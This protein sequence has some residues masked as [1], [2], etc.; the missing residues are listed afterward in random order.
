VSKPPPKPAENW[1]EQG[2]ELCESVYEPLSEQTEGYLSVLDSVEQ[3]ELDRL[4]R[5]VLAR[6]QNCEG[7]KP[8]A[9][10]G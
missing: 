1:T 2:R 10:R 6:F 9:K 5:L 7:T 8:S 3:A 4:L